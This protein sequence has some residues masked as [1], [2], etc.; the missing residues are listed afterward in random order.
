[1]G[2]VMEIEMTIHIDPSKVKFQKMKWNPE[3]EYWDV[4]KDYEKEFI[5]GWQYLHSK[6][7]PPT[8]S[9]DDEVYQM[10]VGGYLIEDGITVEGPSHPVKVEDLEED[11]DGAL[12]FKFYQEELQ[13]K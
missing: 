4:D 6:T 3:E 5:D 10:I 8:P 12:T 11:V 7:P 13:R 2:K 1:M 9:P